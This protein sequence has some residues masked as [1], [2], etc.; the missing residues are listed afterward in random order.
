MSIA[1]MRRISTRAGMTS[2]S[3]SWYVLPE[4]CACSRTRAGTSFWFAATKDVEDFVP[5]LAARSARFAADQSVSRPCPGTVDVD[6]VRAVKGDQYAW[7]GRR[8]RTAQARES[9]GGT[10]HACAQLIEH[11]PAGI[12]VPRGKHPAERIID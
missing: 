8:Q 10:A 3:S 2:E 6:R 4:R 5:T 7:R 11:R 12:G 9:R 1:P